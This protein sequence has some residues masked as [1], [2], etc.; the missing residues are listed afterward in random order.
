MQ[1][2]TNF[3]SMTSELDSETMEQYMKFLEFQKFR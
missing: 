1:K 2:Q 3:L